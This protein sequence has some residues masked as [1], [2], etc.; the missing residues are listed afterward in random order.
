MTSPERGSRE[1]DAVTL[2]I[3]MF[4]AAHSFVESFVVQLVQLEA[5]ATRS[6]IKVLQYCL[7]AGWKAY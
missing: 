4:L 3:G 7:H 1:C 6:D 5:A 2:C